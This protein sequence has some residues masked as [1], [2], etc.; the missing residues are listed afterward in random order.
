MKLFI[1]R[2]WFVVRI[3]TCMS[4]EHQST[5]EC[6]GRIRSHWD[7]VQCQMQQSLDPHICLHSSF[8][9]NYHQ[10]KSSS[11]SVLYK[12]VI[13]ASDIEDFTELNCT[14]T[15]TLVSDYNTRFPMIPTK[16]E[17]PVYDFVW[18]SPAI[19]VV[20]ASGKCAEIDKL[21]CN[22]LL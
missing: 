20:N 11:D 8:T 14:M 17:K 1:C 13:A 12:H 18:K 16:P 4:Y 7:P 22:I 5:R 21:T 3:T 10:Q 2:S 6:R 15:F 9:R 19:R